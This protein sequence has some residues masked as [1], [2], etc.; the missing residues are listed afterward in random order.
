MSLASKIRPTKRVRQILTRPAWML[1]AWSNRHTLR[2]W[3][4][5]LLNEIKT[6]RPLDARRLLTLARA[7][8]R[9]TTDSRVANSHELRMLSLQGESIVADTQ[10]GWRNR[11]VIEEMFGT[12]QV[13]DTT[14]EPSI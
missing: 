2:L 11:Y 6:Q 7:L 8:I 9:V 12:S 3:G 10:P 1:L 4:R 13:I 14:G 5:T